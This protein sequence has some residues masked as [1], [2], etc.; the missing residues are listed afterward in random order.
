MTTIVEQKKELAKALD[1]I[2]ETKENV[3][4]ELNELIKHKETAIIKLDETVT[5]KTKKLENLDNRMAVL[6]QEAITF[7]EI[8][9][10]GEKKT[11]TGNITLTTGDWSTVSTLAKEGIKSR[12]IIK[13][14]KDNITSLLRKITGLES[15]IKIYESKN[16]TDDLK[17]QQAKK[18]APRRLAEVI[19]DIMRKPPE[20]EL[21][22]MKTN[23]TRNAEHRNIAK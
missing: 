23:R 14:L 13:T 2:I 19:V 5:N 6:K 9:R 17:Y 7:S 12:S 21:Q 18:R 16:I 3:S 10:M 20:Q 1:N 4:D 15:K 11:I 22:N 8:D